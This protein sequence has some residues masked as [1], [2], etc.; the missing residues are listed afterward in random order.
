MWTRQHWLTST[1][2]LDLT[3]SNVA[4]ADNRLDASVLDETVL[5]ESNASLLHKRVHVLD[6]HTQVVLVDFA[7]LARCLGHRLAKGPERGDLR[8]ILGEDS[9]GDNLRLEKVLEKRSEFL[10]WF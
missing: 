6:G 3:I 5:L 2:N 4:V 9:I 1:R 8:L 7:E 10:W